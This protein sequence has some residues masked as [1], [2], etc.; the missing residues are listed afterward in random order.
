M[1]ESYYSRT[2][3]L[4]N[5]R[6]EGVDLAFTGIYKRQSSPRLQR[7]VIVIFSSTLATR[8]SSKLDTNGAV[9]R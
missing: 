7:H 2:E 4:Y 3:K 5:S 9:N 6:M 1:E 8:Q